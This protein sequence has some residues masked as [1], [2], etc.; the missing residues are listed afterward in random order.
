MAVDA[1]RKNVKWAEMSDEELFVAYREGN[2]TAM[3]MLLS[4]MGR[5]L[6]GT[7][8]KRVGDR[9]VAEDIFQDTL[10]R[11]VRHRKR[12]DAKKSFRGWAWSIAMNRCVDHLRRKGREAPM[13]EPA[14]AR[15]HH[16]DPELTAIGRE[17]IARFTGAL[18]TLNERQ[19]EVF[20][21][22]EEAGLSFS[23][24]QAFSIMT[25]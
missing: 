20:L 3:E 11:I 8:L 22:R 6:M 4:R 16:A 14:A 19:R 5:P 18:E 21:L 24:V 2:M 7:I 23:S 17:K 12:F 9:D 13:E 25:F 1:S 10:E 15:S